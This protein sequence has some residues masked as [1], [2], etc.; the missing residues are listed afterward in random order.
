VLAPPGL[1]AI[2]GPYRTQPQ[3]SLAD[4]ANAQLRRD[5]KDALAQGVEGAGRDDCMHAPDKPGMT[6]G[7]LNAP[8]VALRALTGNCA[9]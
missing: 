8:V 9:K 1:S 3:R 2:P 6:G 7:L 5:R 4:M